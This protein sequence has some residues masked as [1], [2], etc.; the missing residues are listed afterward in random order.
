MYVYL[1]KV[2]IL[3]LLILCMEKIRQQIMFDADVFSWLREEMLGRRHKNLTQ[4]INELLRNYQIMIK[5]VDRALQQAEKKELAQRE[6]EEMISKYRGQI[7][8]DKI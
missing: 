7:V 3:L 6:V 1:A 4:T 5:S 8:N 2:L